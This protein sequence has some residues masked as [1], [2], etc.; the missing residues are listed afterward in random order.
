MTSVQRSAC[1]GS[2]VAAASS[3]TGRC[4]HRPCQGRG[5]HTQLPARAIPH[6]HH[7]LLGTLTRARRLRQ[8]SRAPICTVRAVPHI[9]TSAAGDTGVELEGAP[10][11]IELDVRDYELDQF[12][13][14]NNAVYSNYVE[15][16]EPG[17]PP[18]DLDPH[19]L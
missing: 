4:A 10:F 1:A 11:S 18:G 2:P 13:V 16:G 19:A 17:L 6:R 14:L 15:H 7:C 8:Q 5:R 3:T 12:G 9:S